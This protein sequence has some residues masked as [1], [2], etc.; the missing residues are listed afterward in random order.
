MT[1]TKQ[2]RV[3]YWRLNIVD[4]QIAYEQDKMIY[5]AIKEND[6]NA[7]LRLIRKGA[8]IEEKFFEACLIHKNHALIPEMID[9][10]KYIIT[11][12]KTTLSRLSARYTKNRNLLK[13]ILEC[14]NVTSMYDLFDPLVGASIH[15]DLETMQLIINK[16]PFATN[17]LYSPFFWSAKSGHVACV[18]YIHGVCK[19]MDEI[20]MSN[21][22]LNVIHDCSIQYDTPDKLYKSAAVIRCILN[23]QK[24]SLF[25]AT[26]KC[27]EKHNSFILAVLIPYLPHGCFASETIH[28]V[29]IIY[30]ALRLRRAV[31]TIVKA[32][33]KNRRIT[34]VRTLYKAM[35]CYYSPCIVKMIAEHANLMDYS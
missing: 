21:T 35:K 34:F 20:H 33:K 31:K 16:F 6:T 19:T 32:L 10:Y 30:K 22:L 11:V 7:I 4:A 23:K 27:F 18:S 5:G 12:S 28:N 26:E 24:C 2:L 15:G 25:H 9:K 1:Y 17:I 8:Y 13:Y 14:C 29:G 3:D